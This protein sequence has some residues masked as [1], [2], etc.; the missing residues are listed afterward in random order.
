M[1]EAG[2]CH[3]PNETTNVTISRCP[4]RAG[5][6]LSHTFPQ[7]SPCVHWHAPQ[8]TVD[9]EDLRL[10]KRLLD[11]YRHA[12]QTERQ[13]LPHERPSQG[14][15]AVTA[16]EIHAEWRDMFLDEEAETVAEVLVNA[17]RRPVAT[18]IG[19]G[20]VMFAKSQDP[21]QRDE[22][23]K[24]IVDR[25][26]LLAEAL[27]VIPCE[28][29]EQ[30]RWGVNVY[31]GLREIR[32][33]IEHVVGI[34]IAQTECIG[35]WGIM[36]GDVCVDPRMPENIYTAWRQRELLE[37]YTCGARIAEIGAGFGG[38]AAYAMKMGASSYT[39][40]DLPIINLLQGFFLIRNHGWDKVKL[41]GEQGNAPIQI[42]PYW[43]L[44]QLP[45]DSFDLAFNKDSMPEIPEDHVVEYLRQIVRTTR[46]ALLSINQEGEAPAADGVRQTVVGR[47]VARVPGLE[48][49]GRF[50]YWLRR[51]YVE[52]LFYRV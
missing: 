9:K 50:P 18:G 42:F 3:E 47:L 21:V 28:N 36:A 20:P 52:E 27:G 2:Q 31:L 6:V 7:G 10:T 45:D 15:W 49:R 22:V 37:G 38:C 26:V 19:S 51:G 29:P 25:L 34:P 30:G 16:R 5:I 44:A 23:A 12:V 40:I 17:L 41:F 46:R 14:I 32:E 33:A 35:L 43:M 4:A 8:F 39:V 13:L 11:A 24:L 1:H 48:R